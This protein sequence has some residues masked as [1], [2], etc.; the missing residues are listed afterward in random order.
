MNK[1]IK[2]TLLIIVAALVLLKGCGMMKDVF[3]ISF[4]KPYRTITDTAYVEVKVA[5]E[6]YVPV[7]TKEFFTLTDTIYLDGAVTIIKGRELTHA[8]TLSIMADYYVKRG[9]SDTLSTEY[10]NIVINDQLWKNKVH[11]RSYTLDLKFPEYTTI[12]T[13]KFKLYAGASTALQFNPE[14]SVNRIDFLPSLFAGAGYSF[15]DGHTIYYERDFA[16]KDNRITYSYN[17]DSWEAESTYSTK[18]KYLSLELKFYIL[19]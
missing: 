8:D 11:S 13:S 9:Y 1:T 19:R 14:T 17:K 2:Y 16:R 5:S 15:R 7:P 6:V 12:K 10:G 4:P 3:G 18:Y